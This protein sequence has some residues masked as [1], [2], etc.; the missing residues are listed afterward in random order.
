MKRD[1]SGLSLHAGHLVAVAAG[2]AVILE[3]QV[4]VVA[5]PELAV[6]SLQGAGELGLQGVAAGE[7]IILGDAAVDQELELHAVARGAGDRYDLRLDRD[8]RLERDLRLGLKL[9]L[10]G[11]GP[12]EQGCR[13]VCGG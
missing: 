9:E 13:L 5:G 1:M 8:L 10:T 11:L 7:G 2:E 12:V 6:G 4:G 3:D